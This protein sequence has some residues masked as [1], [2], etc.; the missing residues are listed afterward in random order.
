[1]QALEEALTHDR[2]PSKVLQF[3]DF[4]LVAITRKRVKQSLER[5]RRAMEAK[6]QKAEAPAPSHRAPAQRTKLLIR[7]GN[8]NFIVDASDVV[9]ATIDDGL[10][11]L[12]STHLEGHSNYRTIEELQ[13]NLDRDTFWRVHRSYLK[14]LLP[15]IEGDG[16]HALAHITGGGLLENVPRVLPSGLS[17]RI[18]RDSWHVPGVFRVLQREGGV[19]EEEMFRAFN[20]GVGMV[21]IVAPDEVEETLRALDEAGEN[22]WVAGE[23]VSGERT[24]LLD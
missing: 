15:L 21:A 6:Q 1:M 4:G 5:A 10:I 22:A 18:R 9:Y 7:H 24:V 16:I 11:T 19:V 2:A 13:A 20:M 8:R 3:N 12:V 14:A 17:A 23:I